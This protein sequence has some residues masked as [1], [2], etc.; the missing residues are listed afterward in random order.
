MRKEMV[1]AFKDKLGFGVS[2]IRWTGKLH[3]VVLKGRLF[4]AFEGFL[5]GYH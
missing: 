2:G 4:S 1:M 3:G 5:E